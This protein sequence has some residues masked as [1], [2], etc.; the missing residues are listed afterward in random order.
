M[1]RLLAILSAGLTAVMLGLYVFTLSRQPDIDPERARIAFLMI[2]LLATVAA[3]TAAGV[4]PRRG[5]AS[6]LLAFVGVGLVSLGLLAIASIGLGLILAGALALL[7]CA[8][9]VN[10]QPGWASILGACGAGAASVAVLA[11]GFYA[12]GFA[13][14]GCPN[15]PGHTE[16]IVTDGGRTVHFICQDRRLIRFWA[17]N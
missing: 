8:R 2:F 12:A 13:P 3:N 4:A 11:I 5:W 10:S 14:P 7:A 6:V 1:I 16:G 15:Q 9:S 17:D